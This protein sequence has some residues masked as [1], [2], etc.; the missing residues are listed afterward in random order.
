MIIPN[1]SSPKGSDP[2]SWCRSDP[3]TITVVITD[4]A[5]N[6]LDAPFTVAVL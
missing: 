2:H 3:A 6:A 4:S 1:R 5:G